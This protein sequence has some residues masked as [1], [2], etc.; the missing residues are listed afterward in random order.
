M[1]TRRAR[2]ARIRN[3]GIV[4]CVYRAVTAVLLGEEVFFVTDKQRNKVKFGG[5]H[6][7]TRVLW[8]YSL[9]RICHLE[10]LICLKFIA[11]LHLNGHRRH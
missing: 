7:E 10:L 1:S 5:K 11:M 2:G 8:G 3:A 4:A 6:I 9:K